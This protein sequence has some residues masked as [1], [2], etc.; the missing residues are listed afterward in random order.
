[1]SETPDAAGAL[2]VVPLPDVPT[3]IDSQEGT[4]G[5][6]SPDVSGFGGLARRYDMPG[7]V[8]PPLEGWFAV[9]DQAISAK[10]PDVILARFVDRGELTLRVRPDLLPDLARVLRDDPYLRFEVCGSVS[11]V[12]YPA[13]AGSELHVVYHL[14]SIT[15]NRRLRL[16]VAVPETNP[17]VPSVTP[18]WP[19][20]NW[21]ERE[22]YDMFGII[23]DGHPGLSRILMPDDWVGWPQRKD[24]PLGGIN[25]QFKGASTPSADN[26]RSYAR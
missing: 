15:H 1:M 9:V 18:T 12:H 21:H 3:L 24:Y 11:G 20:A 25:V 7:L 17:H 23:F 14:L 16:E 6:T 13:Q 10:V 19:M 8:T 2:P 26:R 4:W 22:T 5:N